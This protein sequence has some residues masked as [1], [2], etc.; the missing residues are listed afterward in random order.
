MSGSDLQST[1]GLLCIG[2]CHADLSSKRHDWLKVRGSTNLEL[3]ASVVLQVRIELA[4][5]T[6]FA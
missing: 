4:H 2:R 1:A 6:E 3:R 5:L